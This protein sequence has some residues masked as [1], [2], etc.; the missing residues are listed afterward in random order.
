MKNCNF[1]LFVVITRFY[2]YSSV[3][4]IFLRPYKTISDLTR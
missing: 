2:W 4:G 3:L 1:S